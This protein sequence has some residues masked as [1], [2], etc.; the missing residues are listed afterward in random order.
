[1][2]LFGTCTQVALWLLVHLSCAIQAVAQPDLHNEVLS[3][4]AISVV[5]HGGW[6]ASLT[7]SIF[8]EFCTMFTFQLRWTWQLPCIPRN[9]RWIPPVMQAVYTII[10]TGL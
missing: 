8:R 1:M 4:V 5:K 3:A 7:A 10:L 6:S 9:L 2:R